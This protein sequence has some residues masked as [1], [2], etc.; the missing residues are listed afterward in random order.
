MDND[1]SSD[2]TLRDIPEAEL[3]RML[4]LAYMAF[5]ANLSESRRAL[6]R[7]MLSRTE[8]IGVYDGGALVGVLATY[9]FTFSVPGGRLPCPGLT[10]VCVAPTH[11]RRGVLTRLMDEELRRCAAGGRPLAALWAS[12]SAIYG[13][14]GFG[15]ATEG[16]TLEIDSRQPLRLRIEPDERPLRLVDREEAPALLGPFHDSMLAERAGSPERTPEWWRD[17][18]LAVEGEDASMSPPRVVVLGDPVAGY[19]VYRTRAGEDGPGL[20]QV[21]DLR[22]GTPAVAAALWR[23]LSGIDL[24]ARVRA[25]NRPADDPLLLFA[26][27]RDQVRVTEQFPALWM[28]LIDV[29]AALEGRSWAAPADLVLDV[30]DDRLPANA[31]RHRLTVSDG[32]C[33]YRGTDD[34]AD[35]TLEVRDL[36]AAYL[37]GTRVSDLVRAGLVTEHTPGAAAALDAALATERLPH[38]AD[39]F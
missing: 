18:V 15:A 30:R 13:R 31:G 39:D 38:V 6:H 2:L 17:K 11:R 5:H 28:R 33:G 37:G 34:P 23:Y 4:D 10:Y 25:V 7:D 1:V 24:T 27:D 16:V 32:K 35:L 29:R 19:V 9:P 21:D 8:R 22:A 36:A 26:A 3:D 14:Y 12:E 20:V